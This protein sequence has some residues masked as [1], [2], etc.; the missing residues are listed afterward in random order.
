MSKSM[1]FL[2]VAVELFNANEKQADIYDYT[3]KCYSKHFEYA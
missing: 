2:P 3:N 1:N